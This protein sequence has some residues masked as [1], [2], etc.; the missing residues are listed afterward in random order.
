MTKQQVREDLMQI[1]YYY[2]NKD[3]MDRNMRKTGNVKYFSQIHFSE[4]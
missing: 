4:E 2:I 3:L 1:R